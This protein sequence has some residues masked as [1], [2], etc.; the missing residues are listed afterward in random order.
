MKNDDF[1]R[2]ADKA[3]EKLQNAKNIA[4]D[5]LQDMELDKKLDN[6]KEQTQKTMS[7]TAEKVKEMELDKKLADLNDNVEKHA[8]TAVEKTKETVSSAANSVKEMEIDKKIENSE[9]EKRTGLFAKLKRYRAVIAI[10]IIAVVAIGIFTNFNNYSNNNI[11][12]TDNNIAV[13]KTIEKTEPNSSKNTNSNVGSKQ[14][15]YVKEKKSYVFKED[16]ELC[17]QQEATPVK[18][19]ESIPEGY[20]LVTSTSGECTIYG[21]NPVDGKIMGPSSKYRK[22]EDCIRFLADGTTLFFRGSSLEDN[23]AE[24]KL[25]EIEKYDLS[26]GNYTAGIDVPAGI[27]IVKC[28]HFSMSYD[29]VYIET[30]SKKSSAGANTK[31]TLKPGQTFRLSHEPED[32]QGDPATFQLFAVSPLKN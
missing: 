3:K 11:T 13:D 19:G 5:K 9:F 7:A 12:K 24:L 31:I 16:A 26:E 6:L 18:I 29:F 23:L 8:K 17:K 25:T 14:W 22:G 28:E 4:Q 21:S 10:G 15:T 27:Y 1:K 30:N 2:Y 20:Y 32:R